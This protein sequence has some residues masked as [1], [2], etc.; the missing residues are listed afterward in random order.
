MKYRV[1]LQQYVEQLAELEI[2]AAS[3]EEA[4]DRA[5]TQAPAA[6]WS[7]GY[8]PGE[9]TVYAVHD[10]GGASGGPY[11]VVWTN[12]GGRFLLRESYASADIARSA[13]NSPAPFGAKWRELLHQGDVM[14]RREVA[15]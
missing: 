9:V 3:P 5:L 11:Q 1:F 13:F 12:A 4:R 10:A 2:E 7:P 15:Q 14:I 8:D 6:V